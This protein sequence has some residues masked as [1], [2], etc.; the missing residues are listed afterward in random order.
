MSRKPTL[1]LL[2]L[3]RIEAAC[4]VGRKIIYGDYR[5]KPAVLV[6]TKT[7]KPYQQNLGLFHVV[8]EDFPMCLSVKTSIFEY[9]QY[10]EDIR[11]NRNGINLARFA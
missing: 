3:Q 8:L 4:L 5:L 1:I 2:D 6:C 7:R 9:H 10:I 11:I